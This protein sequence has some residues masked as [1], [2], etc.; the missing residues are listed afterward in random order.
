M[1]KHIDFAVVLILVVVLG[2]GTLIGVAAGTFLFDLQYP[3]ASDSVSDGTSDT[4][5]TSDSQS[6]DQ[7][8]A[9]GTKPEDQ[10]PKKMIA[11]T[12]DDGPH[13]THTNAVLNLLDQYDAKATFFVCGNNLSV[14]TRSTLQ[15]AIS[16]GCEIGNHTFS[17]KDMRNLSQSELLQEIRETNKKIEQYSGTNYQCKLYRPPYGNINL[18]AMNTLYDDGLRMYSVHWSSDSMDWDYQSKYQKGEITRAAAVDGA[19]QTIVRETSEGTV[20]LMHDIKEITPDIL[21]LVL[22]KYTAEGYTFVTV[23]ELFGFEDNAPKEDY[24][25]RYRSTSS[26]LNTTK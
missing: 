19:F 22:E 3:E 10:T 24:F 25:K 7:T 26:I 9:D 4:E 23:S 21:K 8:T 16:L 11:L 2:L 12:F 17:H 13:A 5:S 15:R 18:A 6:S 14:N 20:I 1:N